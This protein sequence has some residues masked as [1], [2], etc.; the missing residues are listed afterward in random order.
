MSA[1]IAQALYDQNSL[2]GLR[3]VHLPKGWHLNAR[4]VP[5]DV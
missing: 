1:E 4:R 3:D 2:V 5:D